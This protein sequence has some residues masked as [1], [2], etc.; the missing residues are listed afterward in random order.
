ME[1]VLK[2]GVI[3]AGHAEVSVERLDQVRCRFL[4]SARSTR[5]IDLFYPVRIRAESQVECATGRV[6]G[7]HKRA[8]EGFRRVKERDVEFRWSGDGTGEALTLDHGKIKRRLPVPPCVQDPISI[9]FAWRMGI[10]PD[11]PTRAAITD[12][13]R[14]ITGTLLE[15]G[16]EEVEVPAGRFQ[17]RH[18]VPVLHGLAGVFSKSPKARIDVWT[19]R[20]DGIILELKSK[21]KVGHF[22]AQLTGE[23]HQKSGE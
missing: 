19:R 23:H 21:V 18:L 10:L 17:A 14:M 15:E 22:T 5:F 3:T 6:L 4:V 1:Y 9:Y 7:Y 11:N 8:K 12:G 20:G 13:K 2:W 16:E